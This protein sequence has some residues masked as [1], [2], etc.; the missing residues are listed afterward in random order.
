[1]ADAPLFKRLSLLYFAVAGY[2]EVVRRLGRPGLAPGFLLQAH[3]TFGPELQAC[4]RLALTAPQGAVRD[5]LLAR[6]D[7]AVEPFDTAGLLD[8]TR[9][10]WYPVLPA[11][12]L[13]ACAK[14]EATVDEVQRLLERC[15]FVSP[16]S[17]LSSSRA[18]GP[19]IASA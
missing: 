9:H 15:G 18:E 12:L 16:L 8:R 14:L 17:Q 11:D 6:I 19:T 7:R 3:A 10:D 1:M 13:G 5:G 2:S 4:A